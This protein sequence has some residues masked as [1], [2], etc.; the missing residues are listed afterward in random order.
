M[1]ADGATMFAVRLGVG[2]FMPDIDSAYASWVEKYSL[3]ASVGMTALGFVFSQ[4][5]GKRG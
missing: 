2:R 3:M 1:V 5:G 4:G